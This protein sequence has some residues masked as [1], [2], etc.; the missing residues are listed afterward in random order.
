V[1]RQVLLVL[2]LVLVLVALPQAAFWPVLA[3]ALVQ[4]LGWLPR[5]AFWPLRRAAVAAARRPQAPTPKRL[6]SSATQ[7]VREFR[8]DSKGSA[9][10][11][12]WM[13]EIALIMH[14][15]L[16]RVAFILHHFDHQT[17]LFL[18]H[19]LGDQSDALIQIECETL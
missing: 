13:S 9:L 4:P 7:A 8:A 12:V 2:V 1:L 15:M 5:L 3:L 19:C 14:I 16:K 17:R 18:K 6:G 11:H 10:C